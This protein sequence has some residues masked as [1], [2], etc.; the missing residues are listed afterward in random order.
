MNTTVLR[1]GFCLVC[2][3]LLLLGC[4]KHEYPGVLTQIDSLADVKPESALVVLNS[5]R[6]QMDKA[7]EADRMY[8]RLL[9]IKAA[10]KA[11]IPH[12]SDKEILQLV[13]YYVRHEDSGLLPLAY[14]YAGSV[15]RDLNDAPRALKYY[16]RVSDFITMK[17]D[18]KFVSNLYNQ[19]GQL[20]L[21]Q[22]LY[23]ESLDMFKKSYQCDFV[24]N[25]TVGMLYNQMDMAVVFRHEERNDSA[26]RILENAF[27]VAS[28]FTDS[29]LREELAIQITNI[30]LK[31]GDLKKARP[32]LSIALRHHIQGQQATPTYSAAIE[33]Y[34]KIGQKD[35]S[36]Y[37]CKL[38][39]RYGN[40]YGK[41]YAEQVLT[42]YNLQRQNNQA[43]KMS[44]DRY[45]SLSDSVASIKSTEAIARIHALYNYRLK[46]KN[47]EQAKLHEVQQKVDAIF[48]LASF[49]ILIL[50]FIVLYVKSKKDKLKARLQLAHLTKL[51]EEEKKRNEINIE[52]NRREIKVLTKTIGELN[53]SN[54]KLKRELEKK[55]YILQVNTDEAEE[56]RNKKEMFKK[57][58]MATAAYSDVMHKLQVQEHLSSKDWAE[59]EKVFSEIFPKFKTELYSVYNLKETE[60]HICML[61]RMGIPNNDIATL[62]CRSSGAVTLARKRLYKKL[63]GT[64]GSAKDFDEYIN[65]IL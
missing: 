16:L 20:F 7:P 52:E 23:D 9:K 10:D 33:Y 24:R 4:G 49:F 59:L 25:D 42:S 61:I 48:L 32:Y 46:E 64:E 53:D 22:E 12:K 47:D 5:L 17:S 28:A 13:D 1:Y 34:E 27:T 51:R 29:M 26:L 63:W 54:L 65:N 44:F 62:I 14:Y 37:Y 8:Y 40:V 19:M 35:S 56:T 38:A 18:K 55:M 11:Y 58:L 50:V 31:K 15:Y 3:C 45:V 36:L 43:A 60:Y 39:Q 57:Q 2:A 6:P 41:C 21:S 30:Y